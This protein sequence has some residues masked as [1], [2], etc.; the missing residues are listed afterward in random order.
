LGDLKALE[1]QLSAG[2]T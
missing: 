1:N 2:K